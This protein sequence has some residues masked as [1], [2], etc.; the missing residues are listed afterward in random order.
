MDVEMRHGLTSCGTVVDADVEAIWPEL[1]LRGDLGL[2]TTPGKTI[3]RLPGAPKTDGVTWITLNGNAVYTFS[4]AKDA[5]FV[6]YVIG[7]A[8]LYNG[9]QGSVL[10]CAVFM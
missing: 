7:G 10:V 3:S 2:F 6:P 8:G 5:S 1:S 9:S 4:G